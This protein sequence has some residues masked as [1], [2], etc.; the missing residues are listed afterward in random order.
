[1]AS[2]DNSLPA[3]FGP[4]SLPLGTHSHPCNYL[5][6]L[7]ATDEAWLSTGLNPLAYHELMNRGF[8]RSGHILYRP[9]CGTCH[10]CVPIRV[11]THEFAPGKSQR[12]N[13]RRNADV[14]PH[15]APPRLTDEKLAVYR[16]YLAVQHSNSP[17]GADAESLREFLYSTCVQS[18]EF[19]YRDSAGN[20]LGISIADLCNESLSSVYHYFDPAH[21]RRGIGV[22]SVLKEIEWARQRGIPW[23]YLGYWIQG[24]P[25]M[26]YKANYRPHELLVDGRWVR[27]DGSRPVPPA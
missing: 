22:F 6:G 16:R 7:E 26:N 10:K 4:H 11:P 21:S 25:T 8:R 18:I 1:M 24:C 19:E 15:V 12:R 2:P 14:R 3:L 9:V 23:Y 13:L 20:L 27:H 5:P 17:Q